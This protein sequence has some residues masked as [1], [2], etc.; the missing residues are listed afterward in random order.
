MR[1][2]APGSSSQGQCPAPR[3]TANS[4]YG[5]SAASSVA[6]ERAEARA[7]ATT[8]ERERAARSIVAAVKDGIGV[9]V[10]VEIVDPESLERSVGK[11]RRIVDLRDSGTE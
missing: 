2:K 3:W 9:S 6:H 10:S 4:A 8:D 11:I 1:A 5:K 7:D